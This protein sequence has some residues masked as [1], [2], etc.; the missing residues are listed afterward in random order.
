MKRSL[1]SHTLV[2]LLAVGG[3][4]LADRTITKLSAPAKVVRMTFEI[5]ADG[6]VPAEVCGTT[7]DAVGAQLPVSCQSTLL[8]SANTIAVSVK[9]LASGQA[10]TF[11]KSRETD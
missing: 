10:L 3:V 2:A 6:T 11:W 5:N 1:L 7:T 4:A 9:G 8:P